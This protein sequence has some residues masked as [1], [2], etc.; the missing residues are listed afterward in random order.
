MTQLI[1]LVQRCN[2]KDG[3]LIRESEKFQ[4]D[5]TEAEILV[6]GGIAKEVKDFPKPTPVEQPEPE[7]AP[8][9]EPEPPEEQHQKVQ[10]TSG[11]KRR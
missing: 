11:K 3:R 6:R 8:I 9:P 4:T 7:D 10:Q 1:C 5:S 2:L